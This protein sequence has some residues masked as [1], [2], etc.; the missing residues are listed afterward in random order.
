[1][2]DSGLVVI[3]IVLGWLATKTWSDPACQLGLVIFLVATAV[4]ALGFALAVV[5]HG[6]GP[7][8][9]DR[10]EDDNGDRP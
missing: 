1:M 10:E 6:R 4:M 7:R 9:E 2:R 3:G 8:P 5:G